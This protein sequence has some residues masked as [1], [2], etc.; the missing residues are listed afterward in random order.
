M[1]IITKR[2]DHG[3]TDLLFN[4]KA[5]KDSPRIEALGAVD[6]LN[7]H[8]GLARVH[9]NDEALV[10]W[11]DGV[12]KALINLM[13]E[14]ATE[15]VDLTRYVEKGYGM[16]QEEDIISLETL[17]QEHE[18][19]GNTFRGWI[20]PGEDDSLLT[21][22]IHVCRTV[23]RRAERRCWALEMESRTVCLY[24]NRLADVLWLIASGA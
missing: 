6:E 13:G 5:A 9:A 12:Q 8:L 17:A 11:I 3:S 2:G 7:A 15:P 24:L 1:P 16:V 20:R 22:Q 14:V 4:K 10:T 19:T 18:E 23:C 21:A